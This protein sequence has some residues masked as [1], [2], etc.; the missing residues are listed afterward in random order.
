MSRNMARSAAGDKAGLARPAVGAAGLSAAM[1]G[2]R[3]LSIGNAPGLTD[4]TGFVQR[5]G[6][7]FF[8]GRNPQARSEYSINSV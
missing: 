6:R 8:A 1:F 3:D 4:R 7:R 5:G 2:A